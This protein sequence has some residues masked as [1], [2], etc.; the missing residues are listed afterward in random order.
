MCQL[1]FVL[2]PKQGVGKKA[3]G[4]K[5]KKNSQVSTFQIQT[6]MLFQVTWAKLTP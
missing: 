4:S 2:L 1:I 6:V 3:G 5:G